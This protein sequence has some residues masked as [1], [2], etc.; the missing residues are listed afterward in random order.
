MSGAGGGGCLR[1]GAEVCLYGFGSRCP[2]L[3]FVLPLDRTS[4]TSEVAELAIGL[5]VVL[6]L[7]VWQVRGILK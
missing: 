4:N 5:A 2:V 3:H 7:M 1:R 6:G